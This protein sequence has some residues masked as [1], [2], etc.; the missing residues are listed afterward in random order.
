[1]VRHAVVDNALAGDGAFFQAVK[2]GCVVL[3]GYD[4]QFGIFRGEYLLGL[5]FIELFQLFHFMFLLKYL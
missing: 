4:E 5:A 1:M 3:V 2:R